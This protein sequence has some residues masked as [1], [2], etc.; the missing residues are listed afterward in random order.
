[1]G[2]TL[3]CAP[4]DGDEY[5]ATFWA[6][7]GSA[8]V[9]L[10][11][12]AALV[13]EWGTQLNDGFGAVEYLTLHDSTELVFG[14]VS[15][16]YGGVSFGE[17]NFALEPTCTLSEFGDNGPDDSNGRLAASADETVSIE[18]GEVDQ[19]SLGERSW[20]IHALGAVDSF[21]CH[22]PSI[23]VMAARRE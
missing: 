21:C 17:L 2:A 11:V 12:G 13:L 8:P 22:G 4:E 14:G 19:V 7:V 16:T 6:K 3:T 23:A 9:G 10:E 18:V 5:V 15:G 20:D 1:M